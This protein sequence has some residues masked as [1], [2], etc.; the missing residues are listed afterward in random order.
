MQGKIIREQHFPRVYTKSGFYMET[1]LVLRRITKARYAIDIINLDFHATS[2]EKYE[3]A[4][5]YNSLKEAETDFVQYVIL[6]DSIYY[7]K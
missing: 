3:L 5:L 6:W 1:K 2:K 4:G 7:A